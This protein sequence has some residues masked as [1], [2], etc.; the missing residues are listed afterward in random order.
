VQGSR[1]A[2]G[3]AAEIRKVVRRL[4]RASLHVVEGGD[5]SLALLK[6]EADADAQEAALHAG[7]DA[8]VAFIRKNVRKSPA[9][10]T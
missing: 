6:R 2:L 4:P 7:A 8:I 5:H 3:N 9:R 1:D 10:G